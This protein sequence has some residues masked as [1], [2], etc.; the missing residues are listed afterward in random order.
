MRKIIFNE[1]YFHQSAEIRIE[2][3]L[4]P[5][6]QKL[7]PLIS[8]Y[9]GSLEFDKKNISLKK[10]LHSLIFILFFFALILLSSF[11]YKRRS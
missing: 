8:L 5:K 10:K 9:S 3:Q 7:T 6:F 11:P 4:Y 1:R 2:I